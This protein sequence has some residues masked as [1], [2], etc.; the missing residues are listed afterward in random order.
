MR[1][2]ERCRPSQG[3][4]LPEERQH[5][6]DH[7]DELEEEVEALLEVQSVHRLQDDTERHLG[8]SEDN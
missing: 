5:E 4:S 1:C 8:D 2:I 3:N 7:G 6:Y